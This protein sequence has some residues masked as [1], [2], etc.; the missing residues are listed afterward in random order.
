MSISYVLMGLL[1]AGPRHGYD[2]KHEH[3]SRLPWSKP[4]GFG[5]VYATIE[6]LERD[7]RVEPYASGQD[8]GPRRT[9]YA[10]TARGR[11]D[12]ELWLADVEPPAPYLG[13]TLF[14]K[15]VVALLA[16][17]EATAVQYLSAQHAAHM[18]RMREL[19]AAKS[20]PAS[21]PAAVVAADYLLAHLD[22]DLRWLRTTVDRIGDLTADLNREPSA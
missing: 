17:D 3:D 19:V 9:S 12:I 18:A 2:L 6:R 11:A 15:V 7:G 13:S 4:L 5:Q 1:A 20:D 8:G 16:A 14:S 10:L 21:T 22:A